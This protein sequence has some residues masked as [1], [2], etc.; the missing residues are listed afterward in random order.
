ML[1]RYG[2]IFL[3]LS[4]LFAYQVHAV[5]LSPSVKDVAG[6]FSIDSQR[7]FYLFADSH[8]NSLVWFI[9]KLA[10]IQKV[11]GS[12]TF[13]VNEK[14]IS[15]GPFNGLQ[16]T[17]F[18]G[19]FSTIVDNN[20]LAQLKVEALM[21]GYTLKPAQVTGA[22]TR[23]LLAGFLLDNQG[24]LNVECTE[25]TWNSAW[26]PVVIPICKAQTPTGEWVPVDFASDF[27]SSLA[28]TGTVD[29]TL[30]FS[31]ETLPGWDYVINDLLN[32]GSSWD[33]LIQMSIEWQLPTYNTQV[34]AKYDVNWRALANYVRSKARYSY[35]WRMTLSQVNLILKEAIKQGTGISIRYYTQSGASQATEYSEVQKL[36]VQSQIVKRLR[37]ILFTPISRHILPIEDRLRVLEVPNEIHFPP[38]FELDRR[39]GGEEVTRNATRLESRYGQII[40]EVLP[41]PDPRLVPNNTLCHEL[42]PCTESRLM[43]DNTLCRELPRPLPIITPPDYHREYYVLKSHYFW[44]LHNVVSSFTLHNT[45]IEQVSATTLLGIDCIEG[46]IGET[47][48]FSRDS[49][50]Q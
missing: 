21:K 36:R 24:Q 12:P 10:S 18:A 13:S 48:R 1:I 8:S 15:E 43:P 5:P 7:G 4:S 23:V 44:L 27:N 17:T 38:R 25:E 6:S 30:P 41:C 45:D 39:W 42:P 20:Q 37:N 40:P 11:N 16:A 35:R 19:A 9:P 34:D 46:R 14:W 3:L 47:L 50:C 49:A 33:G 29:Q 31:G 2:T 22:N 28:S 26:G 32:Y